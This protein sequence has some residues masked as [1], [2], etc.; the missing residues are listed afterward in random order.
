M[1]CEELE[2][3]SVLCVLCEFLRVFHSIHFAG[4]FL[5]HGIRGRSV[6]ES[7]GR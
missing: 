1:V 5:L 7:A 6:L 3:L 4:A 2:S